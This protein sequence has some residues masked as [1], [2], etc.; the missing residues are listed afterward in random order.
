MYDFL[1][2]RG[3]AL[4]FGLGLVIVLIFVLTM[5]TSNQVEEATRLMSSD[6][7]VTTA[8]VEPI[9]MFNTGLYGSYFLIIVSGILAIFLSLLNALRGNPKDL[10][11]FGAGVL[12]LAI[13]LGVAY[14]MAPTEHGYVLQ[15]T[16]E[17]FDISSRESAFISTAINGAIG[18][19][20]IG[21][22]ALFASELRNIF[23]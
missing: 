11:K 14:A 17:Q 3:P 6:Q 18:L 21:F 9:T 13:I 4:G 19:L 12:I 16:M 7:P 22:L 10:L 8:D 15:R 1:S 5:S 23:K 20:G 2:R